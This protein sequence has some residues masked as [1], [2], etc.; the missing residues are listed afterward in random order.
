MTNYNSICVGTTCVKKFIKDKKSNKNKIL[1]RA[2]QNLLS[3]GK[4][5]KINDLINYSNE[6]KQEVLD[7]LTEEECNNDDIYSIEN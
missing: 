7:L 5:T 3:K 2:L 1:K 4:Y 6:I